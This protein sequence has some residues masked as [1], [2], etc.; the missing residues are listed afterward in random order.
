VRTGLAED[1]YLSVMNIDEGSGTVGILALV[2]PLVSWL[3]IATLI[4]ALGGVMALVSSARAGQAAVAAAD[5][6]AAPVR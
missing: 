6:E 4:M 5:L 3:W 1:L 2:N